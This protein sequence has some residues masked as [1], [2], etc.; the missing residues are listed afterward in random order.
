MRFLESCAQLVLG[1]T[2]AAAEPAVAVNGTSREAVG[3]IGRR[4]SPLPSDPG[5]SSFT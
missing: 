5:S 2:I 1:A 3:G 4:L